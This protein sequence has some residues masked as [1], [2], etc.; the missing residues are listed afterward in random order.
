MGL[1]LSLHKEQIRHTLNANFE[2]V[3]RVRIHSDLKDAASQVYVAHANC[4]HL[5]E[6]RTCSH[7][8]TR[9]KIWVHRWPT[10]VTFRDVPKG[11]AVSLVGGARASNSAANKALS[12]IRVATPEAEL[13]L[14]C[15]K[16]TVKSTTVV[17]TTCRSWWILYYVVVWNPIRIGTFI[18]LLLPWS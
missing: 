4:H 11:V 6:G 13:I 16:D 14:V 3:C 18:W 2:H 15:A 12:T 7:Q 1:Q 17:F 9:P 10:P 8:W 5:H